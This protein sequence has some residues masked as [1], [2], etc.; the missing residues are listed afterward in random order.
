MHLTTHWPINTFL[1]D[2]KGVYFFLILVFFRRIDAKW[3]LLLYGLCDPRIPH[4]NK[5]STGA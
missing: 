2:E 4:Q 1:F 5:R 3:Y